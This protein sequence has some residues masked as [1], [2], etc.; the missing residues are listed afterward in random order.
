MEVQPQESSESP[1]QRLEA[2]IAKRERELRRKELEMIQ[3]RRRF[4][5][6]TGA[7]TAIAITGG[8]YALAETD[9]AERIFG[10]DLPQADDAAIA[11]LNQAADDV[12]TGPKRAEP[13]PAPTPDDTSSAENDAGD[14]AVEEVTQ[15]KPEVKPKI[16]IVDTRG[17]GGRDR[18]PPGQYL[19]EALR[20]MGGRRGNPSRGQFQLKLHGLVKKPQQLSYQQLLAMP[21]TEV[22]CDVHCVTKWSVLDT[23]WHGVQVRDLAELCGVKDRVKHVIFEAAH[24]YTANVPYKEAIADDVLV[25]Y[26]LNNSA[27]PFANGSPVRSLVP[28]LYFWKS[29]KW[30]TGIR[31]VEL[32]EPGYWETRGYH[33]H[34]DP[35][36]EERYS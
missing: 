9:L 22:H 34:A 11:K 10:R 8:S 23:V 30:L 14:G 31:F 18:I 20:D 29:A 17:L 32:D 25:T 27:I 19:L 3:R 13:E 2:S 7:A 33:N 6:T 4:M 21:Q 35:W 26:R 16:K 5:L 1:Q 28:G 36:L 15:P 24:G 12:A